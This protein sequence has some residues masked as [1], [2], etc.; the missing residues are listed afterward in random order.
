MQIHPYFKVLLATIFWATSGP[1]VKYIQLPVTTLS[2]YRGAIPV[3]ILALV[4]MWNGEIKKIHNGNIK[5]MI[6]ASVL[7]ALRMI[8]YY[9]AYALTTIGNAIILL[10]TWPI[11]VAI[12]GSVFLRERISTRQVALFG[13]AFSGIIVL[14]LNKEISFQST[15]FLGMMCAF[16]SAA[17]Y[18]ATVVIF[19]KESANYSWKETIFFQ[20]LVAAFVFLPF[21]FLDD[22]TPT[23]DQIGQVVGFFILIGI[24]AFGLFFSALQSIDASKASLLAYC[25]LAFAMA[26]GIFFFGEVL[27]WNLIVGGA[28][29]VG[30]SA[31]LRR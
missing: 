14:T 23:A 25:E 26:F 2:F 17:F 3:S 24:L 19:K 30:A 29:I 31:A 27:T 15:S 18:A 8:F 16:I 20:N 10:F 5:L 4:L 9:S 1:F 12:F 6:G 22:P 28:L 21:I 7:N 11:L 13:V